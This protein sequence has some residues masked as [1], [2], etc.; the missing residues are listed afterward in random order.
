MKKYEKIYLYMSISILV[1]VTLVSGF[2]SE[3][4]LFRNISTIIAIL[5]PA[6]Y[7]FIP[8]VDEYKIRKNR[9][10]NRLSENTFTDREVDVKN[11]LKK[12]LISEHIIE[13]SGDD[14][15]CGKTWIAKKLVDYINFPKDFGN[16]RIHLPY[17]YAYYLDFDKLTEM[18]FEDFFSSHIIN[19]KVVLVCDNVEDISCIISK[20]DLF[21]FQLIYILKD[22]KYVNY[23]RYN[24]SK[25]DES[26]IKELHEKIRCTYSGI[27]SLSEDEIKVLYNITNGNIGKIASV[28][29]KQTS[30]KWIKDI[31]LLN[32]T[33]YDDT[34]DFIKLLLFNGE[35]E[36]AKEKIEEFKSAH[37]EYFCNND[38][39][40]K[41]V[42]IKSDCEHLLN[43]YQKALDSLAII[44]NVPY[45]YYNMNNELE[46]YKAHYLKH[47]WRSDEALN[48][49]YEI[50]KKSFSAKVDSLGILLAKHFIDDE[51]VPY[52][53]QKALEVFFNVYVD[54][55]NDNISNQ[56]IGNQLKHKRC[57]AIYQ[58]YK[59][60]PKNPEK[61]IRNISEVI[62]IY[63]SQNNRLQ[64]NAYFIRGEIQRLYGKYDDAVADYKRCLSITIDNNIILQTNL[65]IYYLVHCKKLNLEFEMLSKEKTI[66]MCKHNNYG[67]ILY[68]RINSIL[69]QDPN[70][71]NI[72]NC[73]ETRIMP[74][75]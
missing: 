68:H 16:N 22:K 43:D 53:G 35:Y 26:N 30:V 24:I 23:F 12:L 42:L 25:F 10:K 75:L 74:I 2:V 62:E 18:Q 51:H 4:S 67:K 5:I 15:T 14:K 72:I 21:H 34:I 66:D 8:L 32:R 46:L 31:S 6:L 20:Q 9:N 29:S 52:S 60:K 37:E 38:L 64:A 57:S 28:L 71:E 61:L 48:I 70:S 59:E 33:D 69:L 27:D 39:Y 47:L 13:I 17:K 50:S 58:F 63:K 49:L 40:Y 54:S 44:E 1:L 19:E 3:K 7:S 55:E 41:Y 36:N 45:C 73:F 65:M 56:E 11:I